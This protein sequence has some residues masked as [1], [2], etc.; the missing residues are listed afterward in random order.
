VESERTTTTLPP[1]THQDLLVP[2]DGGEGSEST[3]TTEPVVAADGSG[4]L[5]ESTIVW[6]IVFGLVT[7]AVL[8]AVWTIRFVLATRPPIMGRHSAPQSVG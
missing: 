7:I 8:I 2:G 4:G 6:L 1:T 5:S 3:T